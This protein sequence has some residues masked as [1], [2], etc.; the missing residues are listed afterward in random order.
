MDRETTRHGSQ[1]P[2]NTSTHDILIPV[3]LRELI[4]VPVVV[5]L[6][7]IALIKPRIGLLGYLWYA[8]MR[9]DL[10]AFAENKYP[11]S[12]CLAV[13]TGLGAL[14][15]LGD[16]TA[17]VRNPISRVVVL[18]Q[19]PVGLSVLFAVYPELTYDRYTFY[20]R[21]IAVLLLIPVLTQTLTDMRELLLV[22]S[23]SLGVVALKFGLYGVIHGGVELAAGYGDML[24]DN[25][26]VALAFAMLLPAC[27]YCRS[28]TSRWSVRLALTG[29]I[30]ACIPA[31]IMSN[32]R[33][34]SLSL[35]LAILL[36]CRRTKRRVI[37]LVMLAA[38]AAGA[39]YLVLDVYVAR[40]A[41]LKNFEQE[42]SAE[43]RIIHAKAAFAMW[44]D[45]PILGVGFGGLNYAALAERYMGK[46]NSHVAHNSY[47]QML[48]D[49][50]AFGFLLYVGML[51][52]PVI[53]LERS[54]R[55]MQR[56][57]PEW[58]A[59]PRAIQVPLAV[60]MLGS[61]FYSCCRMDLPYMLVLS[62]AAW[63]T[64]EGRLIMDLETEQEL[65][66]SG[67]PGTLHAG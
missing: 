61:T 62:A 38:V 26:F 60:F 12:L 31:V 6:C 59:I 22:L 43:S 10:L 64:I 57:K 5:T 42:E 29:I 3:G 46:E 40:M 35:G 49:C 58:E 63:Y 25:N 1:R 52:G 24:S 33:G 45:Y 11:F 56:L 4:F 36:V 21:M 28:L 23:L 32:S 30:G 37:A 27:W 14:R 13:A 9:P 53:W 67:V 20:S 55:R 41:T 15:Y 16:F 48:V 44:R 19:I 65:E 17:I 54:A 8:L 47:L 39:V 7:L 2:P 34:G 18:L 51:L 50:G 66:S